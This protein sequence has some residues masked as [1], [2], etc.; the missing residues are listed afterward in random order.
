MPICHVFL[1]N[2]RWLLEE[3]GSNKGDYFAAVA[4]FLDFFAAFLITSITSRP[5]YFPQLEQA[6]C[7]AFGCPHS[8]Q[9]VVPTAVSA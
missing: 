5:L 2:V 3:R 1:L 4:V 6:M 9:R 7:F 8:L